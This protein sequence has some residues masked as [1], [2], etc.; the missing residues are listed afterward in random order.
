MG[1]NDIKLP[2][3]TIAGLYKSFLIETKETG[4]DVETRE[5][6]TAKV[7]VL[8]SEAIVA[9]GNNQKNILIVVN[10]TDSVHLPD[11]ELSFLTGILGA[12]KLSMG[13]VAVINYYKHSTFSYKDLVSHFKTKNVF[14]F[15]VEP[16]AFGLPMSFPHFQSQI[17]S[18]S[19][20]L[21]APSLTELLDDKVL[22]S[23]LW[24]CLRRIFSV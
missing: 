6:S 5:I 14:L 3:S 8:S 21:F 24:V 7:P 20:F 2:A 22:K 19:S 4:T 12:C 16:D 15:G 17:F 11:A 23:K 10:Y 9:L 13:D 18:N 1:L